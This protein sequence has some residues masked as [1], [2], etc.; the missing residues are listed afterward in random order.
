M[1]YPYSR[2]F[3]DME[4]AKR[5]LAQVLAEEPAAGGD[6]SPPGD[7]CVPVRFSLLPATTGRENEAPSYINFNES[8]RYCRTW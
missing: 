2:F 4:L 6:T 8:A 5:Q 1:N 3:L 7:E